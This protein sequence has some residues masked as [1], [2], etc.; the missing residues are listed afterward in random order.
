MP[1]KRDCFPLW[2][3]LTAAILLGAGCSS[4]GDR[5]VSGA[6]SKTASASAKTS[7]CSDQDG[8][9]NVISV[10]PEISGDLVAFVNLPEMHPASYQIPSYE[11]VAAFEAWVTDVL[12]A[13]DLM[14]RGENV[15][16]H[17]VAGAR[18]VAAG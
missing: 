16:W 4:S 12:D 1:K 11:R 9:E 6:L 17:T 2:S 8:Y 10:L 14:R 3:A 13:V 5:T 7:T 15:N 18:A